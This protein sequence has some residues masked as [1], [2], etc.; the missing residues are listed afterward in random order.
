MIAI[1]SQFDQ[2]LDGDD[3]SSKQAAYSRRQFAAKSAVPEIPPIKNLKRR[4]RARHDLHYFLKTYFPRSTGKKPLCEEQV[5]AVKRIEVA[6]LEE[7]W[8]GNVMPRGFIKST[9]SENSLIWGLGYGHRRY[10]MFF[11]GNA[12]LAKT[13]ISSIYSEFVT[14]RLLLEDFP[15]ICIPFIA[16][17]NKSQR[18]SSQTY[19]GKP[20]G[21]EWTQEHLVLPNIPGS[22]SAGAVLEA[23]GLLA[24]P[25]GAR[26]KNDEGENVRPDIVILDDPQTDASAHSA[27]QTGS[28][29]DYITQSILMLGDHG[30]DVSAVMNATVIAEN[31]LVDQLA[32]ANR[33]PEWQCVRV[34]MVKSMPKRLEDLWL[35]QYAEI[36]R[37]YDRNDPRGRIK[38]MHRSTEMYQI[39]R[40]A[41]D[42][43]AEVTW[44]DIPIK[45]HEASAIQHALN[46]LI[47]KNER[48]FWAECQN[49]P[50]R[51]TVSSALSLDRESLGERINHFSYGVIPDDRS[52]LVFHVDVHDELLYWTVAAV[53]QDF[54]GDVIAYGTWPEQS[55]PW[56]ELRTAKHT[57]SSKYPDGTVEQ[58]IEEGV[59]DLLSRLTDN[60]WQFS[61]GSSM[62][63]SA[64]LV[65]AGYKP[66]EVA[67]AVRRIKNPNVYTSRGIGIGPVEK[68]MPEYDM[69]AKRVLRCG[70]N[71]FRPRWFF[72]REYI[73]GGV[74]RV[75]FDANFWKSTIAARLAQSASA[76]EWRLWG[77]RAFSHEPYVEHLLSERPEQVTAKGRTVNVWKRV[78][79]QDNHWF[80]TLV[81]C[82]V[83]ASIA[84]CVVPSEA[85]VTIQNQLNSASEQLDHEDEDFGF[86]ITSRR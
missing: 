70:P 79:Y 22:E 62:S 47:D 82:G 25:R 36:R 68:P 27:T 8:V 32:D 69:S 56:F 66:A 28:R 52:H 37:N 53:S 55:T 61:D 31:D 40:R 16:L 50:L 84:G 5:A 51:P 7:A 77:R 9:M 78:G 30:M 49:R 38:A 12:K 45:S 6:M 67:R 24:P 63:F 39:N 2:L 41:M 35:G 23:Y 46:I 71:P 3:E 43:G 15:E 11:A 29:L 65:D 18:C 72:P 86:F 80:D 54:S 73:D 42:E 13:G 26:E 33:H 74:L 20:T 10:G 14:N 44:D 48:T 17:A 1:E 75:H 76:G 85:P 60:E 21:I 83:A 57:L 64:G 59:A 4:E 19:R 58:A 34:Q 81:G